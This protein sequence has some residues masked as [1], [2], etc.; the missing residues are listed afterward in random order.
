[1]ARRGKRKRRFRVSVRVRQDRRE[2]G[3]E[4]GKRSRARAPKGPVNTLCHKS[5][6]CYISLQC[7]FMTIYLLKSI[8][9]NRRF[10]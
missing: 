9:K 10:R 7:I 1:M 5:L 6:Y 8:C 2:G 4:R 3:V